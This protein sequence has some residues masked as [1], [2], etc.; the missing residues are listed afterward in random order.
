MNEIVNNLN[1]LLKIGLKTN[2]PQ[3]LIIGILNT[4]TGYSIIFFSL[5]VLKLNYLI[6]N[7]L[8]YFFGLT[9][10]FFLNKH[11]NF[12]SKSNHL[13]ELPK[14][15]LAFIISFVINSMVLFC[16][17]EFFDFSKPISIIIAGIAYSICFFLVSKFYVFKKENYRISQE[18]CYN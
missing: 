11:F 16:A 10:S 1:N 6:S 3:F 7:S 8:G 15:V 13:I 12:K 5:Y 14:F 17:V 4:I 18:D 2:L 9:L